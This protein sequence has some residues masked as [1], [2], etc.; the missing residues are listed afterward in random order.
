MGFLP[1]SDR[2]SEALP[3]PGGTQVRPPGDRSLLSST[4]PVMNAYL[5]FRRRVRHPSLSRCG[6]KF[7]SAFLHSTSPGL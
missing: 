6:E 4:L 2:R 3:Q 7:R 1:S 5:T